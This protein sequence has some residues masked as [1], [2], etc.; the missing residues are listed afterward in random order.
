MIPVHEVEETIAAMVEL[1]TSYG[2]DHPD[3]HRVAKAVE[4]I[5]AWYEAYVQWRQK[6]TLAPPTPLSDNAAL[7]E[8]YRKL[9]EKRL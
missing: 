9:I 2:P 5:A 1:L 6:A 3:V 4:P 8:R 7:K